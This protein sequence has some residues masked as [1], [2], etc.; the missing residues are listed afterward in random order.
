[1]PS[2]ISP[3]GTLPGYGRCSDLLCMTP[4]DTPRR[5]RHVIPLHFRRCKSHQVS[6]WE[7]RPDNS[8]SGSLEGNV[9]P[10]VLVSGPLHDKSFP[11]LYI[12]SVGNFLGSKRRKSK[13]SKM[14]DA[15][16]LMRDVY[17]SRMAWK[18]VATC[19]FYYLSTSAL[20]REG[21]FSSVLDRNIY[22]SNI[23]SLPSGLFTQTPAL[24]TLWVAFLL[25]IQSS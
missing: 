15:V 23:L 25:H 2:G 14:W 7:Q 1:M 10:E 4:S 18:V 6:Q 24:E 22:E 12:F 17:F 9:G 3:R 21:P 8:S 16:Q 5:V 19:L 11:V 13:R 20:M